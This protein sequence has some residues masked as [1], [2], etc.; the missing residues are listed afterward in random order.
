MVGHKLLETV[1]DLQSASG[2]S[3]EPW[4]IVTFCEEP[5]PAYDRVGLSSFFTG[6]TADDLSLVESGFFERHGI[7]VHLGDRVAIDRHA[8]P[9]R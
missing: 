7:T 3:G 6:S 8:R 2:A 5:R 1:A 9:R 4:E